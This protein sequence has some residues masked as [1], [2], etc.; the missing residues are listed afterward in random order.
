VNI[1]KAIEDSRVIGDI[2]STAQ[3]CL[4]KAIYGLTLNAAELG[5]FREATGRTEYVP[6]VYRDV[7]V[8]AGR[9]SGKSSRICAAIGVFEGCIAKH[10]L[11]L[12]ETGVV[13]IVAPTEK[14]GRVTFKLIEA[15]IQNSPTLRRLVKKVRSSPNESEIELTNGRTI[16]VQAANSKHLRSA[17]LI[18]VILEEGC[19]FRDAESG[20]YN[21]GEII[22]AV[23]PG[24]LTMP[25]SK[26]IRV[27]SPWSKSG[28]MYDDWRLRRERPG[29]LCW[30]LPSW[31]M[32][33]SLP[34]DELAVE[35]ERDE[36]YFLREYG[37]EFLDAA[38]ALLP[39]EQVENCVAR[40]Q[41][42]RPPKSELSYVASLDAGFKSDSFAFSIASAEGERVVLD[43]VRE[44]KPRKGHPVQFG[45]VLQEIAATMRNYN[46]STIFGDRVCSEPIR[47]TLL[48][49]GINFT[50]ITTL[51]RRASGIFQTLRAKV[52]AG[53]LVLP[54]NPE[55]VNQLKRL[56]IT[57]GPGGSER[58]EASTGHDD[59][60]VCAALAVHQAVSHPAVKPWVGFITVRPNER[61][62]FGGP[63][64]TSRDEDDV[65]WHRIL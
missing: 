51:G 30:K 36:S 44:W 37:A 26:V 38:S 60:A 13:L 47:Q 7:S 57:V 59:L 48:R 54:D 16:S 53:Q 64:Q 10:D 62:A 20:A 49:E 42:E 11:A 41:T 58:C 21:L 52:I 32:N 35:R 25:G 17:S 43:L 63:A 55:L 3:G 15:R 56:E 4:L 31:V 1:I 24:T 14:Q 61:G 18:C 2:V 12:G 40:G 22:R 6:R 27:S 5:I 65:V 39:T 46:C 34:A 29:T 33:P 50:E 23:R 19:F 9:R 28:P 45:E 8:L